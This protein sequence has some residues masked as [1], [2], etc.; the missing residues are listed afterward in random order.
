MTE[1]QEALERIAREKV[2]RTLAPSEY[3][4]PMD[5][6]RR[7]R[8]EFAEGLREYGALVAEMACK[9]VCPF[10]ADG[11]M[12]TAEPG[13]YKHHSGATGIRYLCYGDM[14]RLALPEPQR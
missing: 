11:E 1:L 2:E 13:K 9:A 6:R 3:M 5:W 7:A 12:P 10:C 4:T 8:V 14:I